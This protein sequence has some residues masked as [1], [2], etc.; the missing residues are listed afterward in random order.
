M[1]QADEISD[2]ADAAPGSCATFVGSLG[3]PEIKAKRLLKALGVA[4]GEVRATM[5]WLMCCHSACVRR[6]TESAAGGTDRPRSRAHCRSERTERRRA[7][8]VVPPSC[9]R[10]RAFGRLLPWCA[11]VQAVAGVPWSNLEYP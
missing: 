5:R 11:T 9:V 10:A 8:A 2:L 7:D 6:R 1:A 3:L 4:Q